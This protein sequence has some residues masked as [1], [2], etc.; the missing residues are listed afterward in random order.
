MTDDQRRRLAAKGHAVGRKDLKEVATIVAADTMFAWHRKLIAQTWTTS[1]QRPGRPRVT[2][3]IRRMAVRMA[4]ENSSWGY[5][6]IQGELKHLRLLVAR[7]TIAEILRENGIK[8]APDRPSSWMTFIKS[9]WG[10][11]ADGSISAS[12]PSVTPRVGESSRVDVVPSTIYAGRT[13]ADGENSVS[14]SQDHR[15]TSDNEWLHL[16]PRHPREHFAVSTPSH[17]SRWGIRGSGVRYIFPAFHL[18]RSEPCQ[19]RAA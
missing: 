2:M 14:V 9:H 8:P 7:S 16:L 19:P 6:R 17:A 12:E 11:L 5:R 13:F 1:S 15:S 4:T 3:E 10:P 18:G